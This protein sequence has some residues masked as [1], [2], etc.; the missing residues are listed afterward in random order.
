[1]NNFDIP[2]N[3]VSVLAALV[4]AM[5]LTLTHSAEAFAEEI[6][7][8]DIT[9][10]IT[11]HETTPLDADALRRLLSE[12]QREPQE[13]RQLDRALDGIFEELA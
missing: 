11:P 5:A 8:I 6:S 13:Q 7:T 1:M 2:R 9:H 10:N 12:P 4:L 3:F